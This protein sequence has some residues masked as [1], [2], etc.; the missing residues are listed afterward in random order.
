MWGA[1][2]GGAL[3]LASSLYSGHKASQANKE[4]QDRTQRLLS[5]NQNWYDRRYNEDVTARADAQQV[6]NRLQDAIKKRN[7]AAEGKA[8]VMGSS[9]AAV[10]AEKAANAEA[11]ANAAGQ[12]AAQGASRKDDIEQ[13]YNANKSAITGQLNTYDQQRAAN[14]AQAG[15]GA[16]SA[17][18]KAG[19]SVDDYLESLKKQNNNA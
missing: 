3:S 1:I 4:A 19:N 17:I 13:Q 15:A 7:Q 9:Q 12:I 2:I 6:L 5:D 16:A 10:A 18:G 11:L 14:I 8:A